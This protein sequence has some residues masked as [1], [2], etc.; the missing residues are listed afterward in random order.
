MKTIYLDNNATTRVAP[1]VL[2]TLF[3]YL[4]DFYGNP[5]SMHAPG[6]LAA[7][8]MRQ[9]RTQAAALLGAEPE[10]I[11]FTSCGTESDNTAVLSALKVRP[12]KRRI[13]TSSVEHPAIKAL[14]ERFGKEGY[15]VVELPVDGEGHLDMD[16]YK[17]SLSPDTTLV[18]IMWANNETGVIFPVEEAAALA[19]E[20]GILFHTD[21]V[22][23]VGKVPMDM[24]RNV[25]DMLSL[26]GH[27][28]HAPKGVGVLYVRKGT[29]FA[30]FM[31]GGHQEKGRRAGT[32][33]TAGIIGLGKA[34]ELAAANLERENGEVRRLRDKLETRLIE[35]I[36]G[37]RVNGG[38]AP[39][40][41]NTSSISFDSVEAEGILLLLDELGICASSGSACTSGSSEPSHVLKAMGIPFS[42]AQGSVRFSLSIYTTE[43]EVDFVIEKAPAIIAHLRELSAPRRAGQGV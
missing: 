17:R 10:E 36:P 5:S 32:E 26:S 11:V 40:L 21:A 6:G 19:K 35:L 38:N 24:K 31:V 14:L 8:K 39:R 28:L 27:K 34:C 23:A 3:A 41:P 30:P 20:R 29:E 12:R 9:A 25:I 1:E 2:E 4:R 15:E 33:N 42:M 7:A 16:A 18:S 43:E 22:Q 13:V 37:A